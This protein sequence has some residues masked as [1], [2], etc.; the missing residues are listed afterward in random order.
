MITIDRIVTRFADL[1]AARW[2]CAVLLAVSHIYPAAVRAADAGS[3][4]TM[5]EIVVT[6]QKREQSLIEVPQAISV[7]SG[8][9]LEARRTNTLVDLP[10]IAPNVHVLGRSG[11]ADENYISIRGI[12]NQNADNPSVMAYVDG[13]P[14]SSYI[15]NSGIFDVER[16]EVIKGPAGTLFGRSTSAGAL[17]VITRAPGASWENL[18]EGSAGEHGYVD[19]TGKVSGPVSDAVGLSV[20]VFNR[21][22]DGWETNNVTGEDANPTDLK[23][24]RGRLVFGT[25]SPTKLDV[26]LGYFENE[27]Y[28]FTRR[29]APTPNDEPAPYVNT[30]ENLTKVESLYGSL[31]LTQRLPLGELVFIAGG[32]TLDDGQAINF[33]YC[34]VPTPD[35]SIQV[36]VEGEEYNSEL[37][38]VVSEPERYDLVIGAFGSQNERKWIT[39]FDPY[40][41]PEQ[42]IDGLEPTDKFE[43]KNYALFGELALN[44][45][46]FEVIVGAR[47]DWTHNTNEVGLPEYKKDKFLPKV[48]LRYKLSEDAGLYALVSTGYRPGDVN[49]PAVAPPGQEVFGPEEV[50]NY[51]I[52]AKA[53]LLEGQLAVTAAAFQMDFE[54]LQALQQQFLPGGGINFFTANTGEARNRGVELEGHWHATDNLSLGLGV[55]YN[56]FKYTDFVNAGVDFTDN[57]VQ[58]SND[59]S[60]LANVAYEVPVGANMSLYGRLDASYMG[61]VWFN[62]A[63]TM[64]QD[65]YTVFNARLGIKWNRLDVSVWA[66]NL[67]DELYYA[68]FNVNGVSVPDGTGGL[69]RVNGGTPGL[70][71]YVGVTARMTF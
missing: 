6:A 53:Y 56:E 70:P 30:S 39:I 35:F 49:D 19:F 8:A 26:D 43:E 68:D 14:R 21:Q 67:F 36:K 42:A 38:W 58:F 18:I 40:T 66:K 13:V 57:R 5:G 10:F 34:A 44:F 20:S 47:Q 60:G 55:A 51:E 52:G 17:N 63:N 59:W 28:A 1:S 31:T 12:V 41:D 54:G 27:A 32:A 4:D 61:R 22:D 23:H 16:L 45:D 2:I 64:E 69:P 7:V 9:E 50:T 37:R 25:S 46:P 29:A 65:P 62:Q 15:V 33:C 3:S 24:A 48:A 71:R 11:A